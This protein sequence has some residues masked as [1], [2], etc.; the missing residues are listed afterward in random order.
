MKMEQKNKIIEDLNKSGFASEMHV[1]KAFLDDGWKCQPGHFYLDLEENKYREIDISAYKVYFKKNHILLEFH[2][3]AE[4]KK[5]KTPWVVFTRERETPE[6]WSNPSVLSNVDFE[7][8]SLTDI[9]SKTSL[10]KK[11][12]W[13]GY[14]IHESFK[15]PNQHNRWYKAAINSCKASSSAI[16]SFYPENKIPHPQMEGEI[17]PLTMK[18]HGI[19]VLTHPVIILDGILLRA[20]LDDN[21]EIV[22]EEIREAPLNFSFRTKGHI[23]DHFRIDIIQIDGINK[24]LKLLSNRYQIIKSTL[25]SYNPKN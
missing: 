17:E 1:A 13:I 14:G 23:R 15:D 7:A 5:S 22:L 24:Y 9:L 3:Y 25:D 8:Y 21:K 11:Y 12:N 2:I 4:V 18:S 19:L 20:F 6:G 10:S 16:A